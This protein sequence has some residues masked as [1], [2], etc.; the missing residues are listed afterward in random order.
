MSLNLVT[1]IEYAGGLLNN[2]EAISPLGENASQNESFQTVLDEKLSASQTAANV[3]TAAKAQAAVSTQSGMDAI[4]EEASARYGVSVS[5]LKAVAKAESNFNPS[6]V[7]PAGAIGVMQLMPRTA[8]GLGVS[9]PYDARQNIMG[10]AK[11]LSENLERFG[12][13]E[14]ALAAYNAGPNSVTKYG[15]VP[16]YT[17]TQ[18]YVKKVMNYM[19]DF[20]TNSS[21]AATT[22]GSLQNYYSNLS[23]LGS[24]ANSLGSLGSLGAYAT[25]YGM[26]GLL[27]NSGSSGNLANYALSYGMLGLL[28]SLGSSNSLGSYG[29]LM[30]LGSSG[31]SS[32]LLGGYSS[33]G[34]LNSL[35]GS[36]NSA[37]MYAAVSSLMSG[38][39]EDEDTV[40]VDKESFYNVIELMQ[41]QMMTSAERQIGISSLL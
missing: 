23:G 33:L 24:Y 7:S 21:A 30:G 10:G 17:E 22:A 9:D 31:S 36:S 20:G 12:D 13:V 15:G 5:L 41:L 38:A 35:T 27:S 19:A 40:T 16:P 18:N 2:I 29:S 28:N 11:Y 14:L 26:L 4:F 8:A 32:G 6:A 37:L 25:S 1:P 34:S 39:K 3:Q